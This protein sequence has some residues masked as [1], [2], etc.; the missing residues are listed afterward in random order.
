M[1]SVF[2]PVPSCLVESFCP[3]E[4]TNNTPSCL[5]KECL[6]CQIPCFVIHDVFCLPCIIKN[7]IET[8][9]I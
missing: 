1:S 7:Y 9:S 4:N 6:I 2:L 8:K 5:P 3:K